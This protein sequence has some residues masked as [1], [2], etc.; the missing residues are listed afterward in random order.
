MG[1][2]DDCNIRRDLAGHV[3]GRRGPDEM[4]HMWV[5][6]TYL[7]DERYEA[8]LRERESVPIADAR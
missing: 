1:Q 2:H 3:F 7:D 6:I 4:S 8:M 5:N